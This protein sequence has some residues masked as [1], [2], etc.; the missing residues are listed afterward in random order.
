MVEFG[1]T[2]HSVHDIQLGVLVGE[3]DGG[4]HVSSQVNAQD[5]DGGEGKG[6]VEKDEED[7]GENLR[8]VRR[9]GV[10]D[11]FLEVVE[12][13]SSFFYS[14]DDRAEVIV[15]QKHVGG[16]LGDIGSRSHGN[17]NIG[18]LDGRRV[19][20]TIASDSDDVASLLAGIDN[21]QFLRRSGSGEHDFGLGNPVLEE[22]SLDGVHVVEFFLGQMLFGE[23]VSVD[24]NSSTFFP[25]FGFVHALAEVVEFLLRVL[26]DVDFVGDGSSSGGLISGDHDDLD[27]GGSALVH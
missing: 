12:D 3:G 9:Q 21:E 22:L 18:L 5:E 11:R 8:D 4:D 13:K 19:V 6:H 27:S 10:G 14:V 20:D 17:S 16:V 25:S 7:E 26:D 1:V 2:G 15:E 23:Q 24:D